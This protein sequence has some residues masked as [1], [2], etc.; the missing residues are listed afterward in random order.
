MEI[1]IEQKEPLEYLAKLQGMSVETL[2]HKILHE[3][4]EENFCDVSLRGEIKRG[5]L[6][7]SSCRDSRGRLDEEFALSIMRDNM[8]LLTKLAADDFVKR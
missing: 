1:K 8:D 5:L 3:W 4:L 6:H 2:V 7:V